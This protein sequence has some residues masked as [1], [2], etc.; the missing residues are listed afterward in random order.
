MDSR[1]AST[2][3]SNM[4]NS[5]AGPLP[6]AAATS[7]YS[8]SEPQSVV[9]LNVSSCAAVSFHAL[10]RSPTAPSVYFLELSSPGAT[11][12]QMKMAWC[13]IWVKS[14][15]FS[16]RMSALNVSGTMAKSNTDPHCPLSHTNVCWPIPSRADRPFNTIR[17]SRF[18]CLKIASPRKST[19]CTQRENLAFV[20][21]YP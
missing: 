18:S 4:P 2:N 8:K 15:T 12:A 21:L 20:T 13:C 5:S 14:Q 19:L 17:F 6:D 16:T 10:G 7:N 3:Y 1:H 9:N 11:W